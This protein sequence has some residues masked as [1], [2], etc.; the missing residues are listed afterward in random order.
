MS[1]I[2][3]ARL[4]DVPPFPRLTYEILSL[5]EV[6]STIYKYHRVY[7]LVVMRE[8]A[9]AVNAVDS[10]SGVDEV[11]SNYADLVVYFDNQ[12][13]PQALRTEWLKNYR[14]DFEIVDYQATEQ[15]AWMQLKA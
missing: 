8:M 3:Q 6:P 11:Q 10:A 15:A 14:D 13:G 9:Q 7:C 2:A 12:N 5:V 1:V 4:L